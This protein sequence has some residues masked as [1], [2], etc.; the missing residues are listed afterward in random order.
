MIAYRILWSD[1]RPK[2]LPCAF[3]CLKLWISVPAFMLSIEMTISY[4]LE[5]F[6]TLTTRDEVFASQFSQRGES[7]WLSTVLG[8]PY[9]CL[10]RE[11]AFDYFSSSSISVNFTEHRGVSHL[12]TAACQRIDARNLKQTSLSSCRAYKQ[13]DVWWT[14]GT[15]A[16]F[17]LHLIEFQPF[18]TKRGQFQ[19]HEFSPKEANKKGYFNNGKC[20]L[21]LRHQNKPVVYAEVMKQTFNFTELDS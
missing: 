17:Y 20:I 18:G 3:L 4:P 8:N 9:I 12:Y 1:Y 21:I 16:W 5:K 15:A 11:W 19:V 6:S 2:E 7:T 13:V 10:G 14:C